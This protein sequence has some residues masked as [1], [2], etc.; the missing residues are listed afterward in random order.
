MLAGFGLEL[1]SARFTGMTGVLCL[2]FCLRLIPG[3]PRWL[4]AAAPALAWV[5][6]MVLTGRIDLFPLPG[7][8]MGGVARILLPGLEK[9]EPKRRRG[10]AAVAQLRLEQMSLALR[11]MEQSLLLTAPVKPD[12][13]AVVDRA[14]RTN[15]SGCFAAGDCTG[16]PYQLAKAVGEGNVAAHSILEYLAEK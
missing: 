3:R 1:A 9:W 2:G 13:A 8:L 4:D 12:R 11:H 15:V 7:L 10:E 6:V 14:Q 16:R 5:P